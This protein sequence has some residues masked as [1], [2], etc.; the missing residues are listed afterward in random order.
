MLN[1][2][3][4]DMAPTLTTEQRAKLIQGAFEG[5]HTFLPHWMGNGLRQQAYLELIAML[6]KEGAY[7]PYSK[8]PIGAAL[9][10]R[11]G[12]IVKGASIDNA[13]YGM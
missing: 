5:T 2:P 13:S 3:L 6:A 7:S 12:T 1:L 9:L 8:F 4:L 11:G 10:T